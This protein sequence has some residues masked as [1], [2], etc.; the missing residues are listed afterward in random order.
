MNPMS[1]LPCLVLL[2]P[3]LRLPGPTELN[4][5]FGLLLLKF[6]VTPLNL[7][8]HTSTLMQAL[9][10]QVAQGLAGGAAKQSVWLCPAGTGSVAHGPELHGTSAVIKL[11]VPPGQDRWGP[12]G[13]I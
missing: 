12:H 1:T 13:I 8:P 11:L 10:Y 5:A 9:E 4:R 6:V 2:C 7:D 3:A